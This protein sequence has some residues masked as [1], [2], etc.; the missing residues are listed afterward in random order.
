MTTL[1]ETFPYI[2]WRDFIKWN[3]KNTVRV[4]ENEII[5]VPDVK[6]LH[7]LE[8]ILIITPKRTIANVR[9]S[10]NEL[11]FYNFSKL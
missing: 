6:Y 10:I 4:S 9:K 7:Q 2:D 3:L 5:T 11:K 8:A 1:Q